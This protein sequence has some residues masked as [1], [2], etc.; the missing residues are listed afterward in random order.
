M[1]HD[2]PALSAEVDDPLHEG[3]IDRGTGRVVREGDH[4]HA[5]LRPTDLVGGVER[6]EEALL[7]VLAILG[8]AQPPDR[9]LAEVG[10]GEERPVHVDRVRRGRDDR[11]I[12]ALEQHPHEVGEALLGSDGVGDLELGVELDPPVRRVVLR[13]LL[14]EA[15][16]ASAQRVAV[17]ARIARGLGELLDRDGWRGDVG[18]AEAEVD[19]V[20]TGLTRLELQPVDDRED[21]RGKVRDAPEL[22]AEHA[23]GGCSAQVSCNNAAPTAPARSLSSAN[24]T[25]GW[26]RR[27]GW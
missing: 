1:H 21:V 20:G 10:A 5:R 23:T 14:A 22:H 17:V 26:G 16:Q 2:H 18:V 6:L 19:H 15:R 24:L 13:D 3:E 7:E 25:R 4:E 9:H 8:V 11:G 12:A 27:S